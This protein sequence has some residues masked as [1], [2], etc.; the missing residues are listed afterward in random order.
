[1][2]A[3]AILGFTGVILGAL[4]AHAL[5]E[6]LS[7]EALESFKTGVTYQM[8]HALQLLFIY[9]L[10]QKNPEFRILKWAQNLSIIGVILFSVSIYLLAMQGVWGI[11]L[12]FLGPVTP[13][14]GLFLIASWGLLM[15]FGF[16]KSQD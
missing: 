14:G 8:Y 10:I 15:V 16:G 2:K 12:R 11:S 13:I 5:K 1:M 7:P 6:V 4:G 3:A 9:Y